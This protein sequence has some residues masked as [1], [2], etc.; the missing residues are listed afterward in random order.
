MSYEAKKDL[1]ELDA[2]KAQEDAIFVGLFENDN[3]F[4][5]IFIL[6]VER[7]HYFDDTS[8]FVIL[9]SREKHEKDERR[10]RTLA[11]A[12]KQA[13][14]AQW[15]KDNIIA[16]QVNKFEHVTGSVMTASKMQTIFYLYILSHLNKNL[17]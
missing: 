11:N 9:Q 4:W 10:R 17:V 5:S 15:I 12:V 2:A 7:L 14:A 16:N 6:I 8:H 13:R 3:W 1:E